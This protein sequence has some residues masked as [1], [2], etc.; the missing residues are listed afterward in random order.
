[1]SARHDTAARR[2]ILF[3]AYALLFALVA[4]GARSAQLMLVDRANV[5]ALE[6]YVRGGRAAVRVRPGDILDRQLQPVAV[7]V[8]LSQICANPGGIAERDRWPIARVLGAHLRLRPAEILSKLAQTEDSYV[9]IQSRVDAATAEDIRALSLRGIFI[10]RMYERVYPQGAILANVIGFREKS[11][12]L[13]PL[14]GL[15]HALSAPLDTA[16]GGQSGSDCEAGLSPVAWALPTRSQEPRGLTAVLTV[17]LRIQAAAELALAHCAAQFRPR[18]ASCIVL[19]ARRGA[20]LAMASLP[21]FDPNRFHEIPRDQWRRFRNIPASRDWEPGSVLKVVI[22][23]SALEAGVVT[24]DSQFTCSGTRRIADRTIGC[25]G[26]YRAHGHGTLRVPDI[27]ARS[28]NLGAAQIAGAVGGQQLPLW[29]SEFGLGTA[30]G[31]GLFDERTGRVPEAGRVDAL[32]LA[33][34]GFGQGL[35][36]TDLQLAAAVAALANDGVL[37]RPFIVAELRRPDGRVFQRTSPQQ[38]RRVVSPETARTVIGMMRRAVEVGTGKRAAIPG[39]FVA[40]KTGTAQKVVPG[41]A[42]YAPGKY[43]SS[44]AGIIGWEADQPVVILVTVDEP[45][46]GATG[47]VAAAPAFR[48]AAAATLRHLGLLP[49][50]TAG[51][52]GRNAAS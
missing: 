25:W 2:R 23:A 14:W 11:I 44:F 12:E 8:E 13:T 39:A 20:V 46:A 43:I 35:L 49:A 41:Q 50:V 52:A 1:M 27:V 30:T 16:H 34:M 32:T 21:T 17:D 15:E 33:T 7:S 45:E 51:S 37:M 26:Q 24:P 31:S 5:L 42:G 28:C 22:V 6:R 19:D 40:G 29:L 36:T 4:L 47:G 18:A 9:I 38:V 10:E 3:V 48:E